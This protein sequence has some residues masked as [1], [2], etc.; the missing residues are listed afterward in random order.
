LDILTGGSSLAIARLSVKLT[1]ASIPNDRKNV[2]FTAPLELDCLAFLRQAFLGQD[3]TTLDPLVQA[4]AR[5][6]EPG[7]DILDRKAPL[8]NLSNRFNIE[9]FRE[10]LVTP[11]A[12]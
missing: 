12:S 5:H 6:T 1:P 4:P 8:R 9:I 10:M 7:S 3:P 2:F 11:K